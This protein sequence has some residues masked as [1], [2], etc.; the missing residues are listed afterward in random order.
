[1]REKS[2]LSDH[3]GVMTQETNPQWSRHLEG[4]ADELRHLAIA[5]DVRLRDPG[6]IERIIRGDMTVCGRKNEIGFEKL[7]KLLMATY[8]SLGKAIGRIGPDETKAILDAIR[9]HADR[10]ENPEGS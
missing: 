3:L 9:E 10:R 8:D 1:M 5:C 6:V 4:I 2:N 7:R